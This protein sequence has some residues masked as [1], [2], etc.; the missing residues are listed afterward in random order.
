VRGVALYVGGDP[1]RCPLD[2][3]R[4]FTAAQRPRTR[5]DATRVTA[6]LDSG[7]FSDP[8]PRRLDP[9][10]ALER[11]L[12]WERRATAFWPP[13]SPWRAEAL[14]SYDRL[15]DE[16]WTPGPDG[17]GLARHK[18]RWTVA[19]AEGAVRETVEAARY[20]VAQRV[21]LAP[22]RLV[23][24]C[25]GVDAVQYRECVAEVLKVT[26]PG[27]WLG[28]GGWCVL[29]RWRRRWLPAFWETLHACLPLV[30]S[31]GIRR[32]H[33]FGVLWPQALGGLLWLADRHG[34]AVSTDSSAPLL[35]ATW[36]DPKKAGVRAATYRGNV[37]WWRR[38]LATLRGSPHYRA[39]PRPTRQLALGL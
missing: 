37:A 26:T 22:R 15:I 4:C 25:Q 9:E 19:A 11:Q 10:R 2:G 18:R 21:R 39:P 13:G 30:S 38:R 5:L 3:R 7:A 1:A 36:P 33:V 20:L 17:L 31:A 28:L 34:L 32:V 29:G 16:I 12:A 23:L 6:L 14:V 27:D 8:P 35:A 24:A